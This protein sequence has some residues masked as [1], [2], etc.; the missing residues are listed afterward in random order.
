MTPRR[1]IE[2]SAACQIGHDALGW[3]VSKLRR[4]AE[5]ALTAGIQEADV[6]GVSPLIATA[7][8]QADAEA[9][10]TQWRR[11]AAQFRLGTRLNMCR[12]RGS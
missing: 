2:K 11:G 7:F 6:H 4:M 1:S 10:K 9:A 5:K 12:S 3:E 8:A